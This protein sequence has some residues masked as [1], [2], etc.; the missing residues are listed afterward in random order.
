MRILQP[1]KCLSLIA[2]LQ[3]QR[4]LIETAQ[5][6]GMSGYTAVPATGSGHSGLQ[7]GFL[8]SHTNVV[9]TILL[10]PEQL[11]ALLPELD[12][13]MDSG[14]TMK[15]MVSDVS[16]LVPGPDHRKGSDAR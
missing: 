10:S 12:A 15:V 13:L 1:Q 5:R 7:A 4:L 16:V 6:F 3:L 14:Y 11:D 9:L 8:D 2:P